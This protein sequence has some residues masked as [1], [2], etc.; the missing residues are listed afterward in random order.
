MIHTVI[1]GDGSPFLWLDVVEPTREEL[2]EL[3][4]E[5]GLHLTAI[6]DSLQPEHLPKYE[7]VGGGEGAEATAEAIFL[8]VRAYDEQARAEATTVQQLT[9]K[10]A[11]FVTSKVLLTIHRQ[12]QEYIA[13]VRD[14]WSTRAVKAESLGHIV[15]DLLRGVIDTYDR[16]LADL[17][18][19][20]TRLE[21]RTFHKVGGDEVLEDGYFVRRRASVYSY[22]LSLTADILPNLSTMKFI[23]KASRPFFRDLKDKCDRLAFYADDIRD[24]IDNILGLHLALSAQTTNAASHRT[25]EVM[26]LLTVFSAF[27]L[28]LN[29]IASIYGM[30]FQFMPEL[31]WE[32]GYYMTLTVMAAVATGIFV[33]FKKK[34]WMKA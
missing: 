32:F 2:T 31:S 8:I 18:E 14:K 9:R 17:L 16:P 13:K 20:Q 19:G 4:A 11:I 33:W 26:R 27:F 24:N 1:A 7:F 22:M 30:N 34:G 29:F 23:S 6:E 12:D 5:Y 28:P 10:L 25:N 21:S 3:A 15:N